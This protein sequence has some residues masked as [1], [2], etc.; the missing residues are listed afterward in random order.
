MV[1]WRL[2]EVVSSFFSV[3]LG[4]EKKVGGGW[5]G[6]EKECSFERKRR[7]AE[8]LLSSLLVLDDLKV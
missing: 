2:C 8:Q 5:T 7:F 6:W 1:S 4:K 3:C